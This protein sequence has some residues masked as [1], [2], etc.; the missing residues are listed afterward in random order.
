[1]ATP[2]V[3]AVRRWIMTGAVAAITV[4]GTIYGAGLKSDQDVKRE[5]RRYQ[6]A[7]PEEIIS[8][9]QIARDDLVVKKNELE[10]KIAG[11][12]EK[13][14]LK[15]IEAQR[16]QQQAQQQQQQQQQPR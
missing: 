9:L 3:Q 16:Q 2:Q 7:S 8:Q 10:R 12:H 11:F 4:T 13:K 5:R 6:Q 1:M 14:K 15:E